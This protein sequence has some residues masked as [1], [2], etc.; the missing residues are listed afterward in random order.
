MSARI[1]R[2]AT[3]RQL[4]ARAAQT[5]VSKTTW[6]AMASDVDRPVA[7]VG[8]LSAARRSGPSRR[9]REPGVRDGHQGAGARR[10]TARVSTAGRTSS[11]SATS[12]G[13]LGVGSR[14]SIGTNTICVGT[15]RPAPDGN[16]ARRRARRQRRGRGRA[17]DRWRR[18]ARD[19]KGPAAT[20]KR[21]R[22]SRR[23]AAR[24]RAGAHGGEQVRLRRG[25]GL[26]ERVR[27]ES[28]WGL[29]QTSTSYLVGLANADLRGM[30]QRSVP[31][32]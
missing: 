13:T 11:A 22:T 4:H 18:P 10:T 6:A 2:G 21:P 1:S 12:S 5:I 9:E 8:R 19:A 7:P 15:A 17:R 30:D 24:G 25:A 16:S 28:T 32:K 23:R 20:R 29:G 26:R 31:T 14:S 3:P 27:C